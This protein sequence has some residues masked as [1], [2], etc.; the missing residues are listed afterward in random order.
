MAIMKVSV[1]NGVGDVSV[2][3][4]EIPDVAAD[5]VLVEVGA[6]GVCGSDV[7]Y[8]EHGRIGPYVVD[9]PLI[10]GHEAGGTITKVG[11]NVTSL[12]VGQRVSLEPGIPC[13]SCTQCLAGRYSTGV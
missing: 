5:Q 11:D 12:T 3:E 8:Y 1:L 13:R 9:S 7:H 10:L 6:V 2:Q 4:R